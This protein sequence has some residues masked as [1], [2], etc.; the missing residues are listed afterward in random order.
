MN[1]MTTAMTTPSGPWRAP[2]RPADQENPL[3]RLIEL[4]LD[5]LL[6]DLPDGRSAQVSVGR[7]KATTPA[8]T[9]AALTGSWLVGDPAADGHLTTTDATMPDG[10]VIN[11]QVRATGLDPGSAQAQLQRFIPPLLACLAFEARLGEQTDRARDAVAAIERLAI[12]DLATGIVMAHRDCDPGT[13]RLV[14]AEWSAAEGIDVQVLTPTDVLKLL[15]PK[16]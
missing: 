8:T 16:D 10:T 1:G 11:L 7:I 12:T 15:R 5:L 13:A 6:H 3:P 14:L 4:L 9:P 2:A